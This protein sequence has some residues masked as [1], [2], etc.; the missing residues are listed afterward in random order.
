MKQSV[1]YN[2]AIKPTHL[3]QHLQKNWSWQTKQKFVI[4][5]KPKGQVSNSTFNLKFIGSLTSQKCNDDLI[6]FCNIS[7]LFAKSVKAHTIGKELILPTFKEGSEMILHH[8]AASNITKI[9]PLSNNTVKRRINEMAEDVE[10]FLWKLLTDAEF[11]LQA[12]KSTLPNN[13]VFLLTYWYIVQFVK[14]VIQLYAFFQKID[15]RY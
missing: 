13:E 8:P 10:N 7:K 5:Y 15:C 3:Q 6:A 4:F 1:V 9:I 2:E 14:E 11:S 12:D